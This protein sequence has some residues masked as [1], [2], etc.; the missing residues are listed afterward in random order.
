MTETKD[1]IFDDLIGNLHVTTS[2]VVE[3]NSSDDIENDRTITYIPG[4]YGTIKSGNTSEIVLKGEYPKNPPIISANKGYEFI[5]W[6]LTEDGSI[7][8]LSKEVID[9][10]TTYYAKYIKETENI[11]EIPKDYTGAYLGGYPDKT[12]KPDN[13]MTR[14]EFASMLSEVLTIQK[15]DSVVELKDVNPDKWYSDDIQLVVGAGIING[16][17]DGTF[18][19]E[20]MIT[21]AEATSI[22]VRLKDIEGVNAVNKFSDI[23]GHWAYN[24]IIKANSLGIINGYPDATFRPDGYITR[25]EVTKIMNNLLDR[26][27]IANTELNVF[28]DLEPS[29]WAFSEIIAATTNK[30]RRIN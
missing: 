27:P 9:N 1:Y 3:S 16:Y 13:N 28:L 12:F 8:D 11:I 25:A 30:N 26:K 24:D 6:S 18:R 29:N 17:S 23:N 2:V 5:G 19:P 21:R 7:V 14:A 20:N 4:K 22:I 10:N 15:D